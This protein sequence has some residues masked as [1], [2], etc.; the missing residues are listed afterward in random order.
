MSYCRSLQLSSI[1]L[2]NLISSKKEQDP[3]GREPAAFIWFASSFI[4]FVVIINHLLWIYK[5]I[6]RNAME[7]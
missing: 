2:N 7:Y 3:E 1:V 4:E 5:A 6:E